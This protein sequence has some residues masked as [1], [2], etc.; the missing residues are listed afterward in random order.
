V[1]VGDLVRIW[2]P[3]VEDVQY[4][5]YRLGIG[6]LV[7][8]YSPMRPRHVGRVFDVLWENGEIDDLHSTE[9]HRLEECI[10]HEIEVMALALA[11]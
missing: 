8:D 2:Q 6:V 4:C 9:L 10:E 3:T 1:K 7:L 11:E 5:P